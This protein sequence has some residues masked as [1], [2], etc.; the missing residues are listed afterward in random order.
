MSGGPRV[1]ALRAAF[2]SVKKDEQGRIRWAIEMIDI[3]EIAIWRFPA[4]AAQL[5][6]VWLDQQRPDGL[7]MAAG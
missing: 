2:E 7:G 3:D 5:E 6:R 1:M 4:L